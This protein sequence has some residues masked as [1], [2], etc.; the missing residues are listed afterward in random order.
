MKFDDIVRDRYSVRKYQNKVVEK[1]LVNQILESGRLAPT[2][3]CENPVTIYNLTEE[4]ILK[5]KNATQYTF[6]AKNMFLICYDSNLSYKREQDGLDFGVQDVAII[7]THMM[8]KITDLGLGS[9]WVGSFCP[10]KVTELFN[11]EN[12]MIPVALLPFGY[13]SENSKPSQWHSDRKT[14]N[15]FVKDIRI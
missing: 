2:A 10:K 12:N 3:G 9:C 13:I 4:Q 7:T 15:E 6:G 11:L 5:L 1:E 8:L 14:F